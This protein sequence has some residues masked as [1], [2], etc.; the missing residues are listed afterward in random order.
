MPVYYN[1]NSI[2]PAPFISFEKTYQ[3][4]D[5]GTIV[6]T[7]W[8]ISVKGTLSAYKGSPNSTG[9]FWNVGG[10]PPDEVISADS[11]LTSI[12]RKQ[13]AL[14]KLFAVNG[15]TYEV[16]PWDGA[17]PLKF[18]PR[19]KKIIFPEGKWVEVCPYEIIMEADVIYVN[20]GILGEDSLVNQFFISKS[21]ESWHIEILN[22]FTREYRLVH[23]L[24]AVGKLFYDSNGNIPNPAWVNAQNYVLNGIGL[25]LNA[26]MMQADGVLGLDTWQAFNYIR[27]QTVNETAGS[28]EA[29]ETWLCFDTAFT[30]DGIG[31]GIPAVEVL[32]VTTRQSIEDARTSVTLEGNITGLEQRDNNTGALITTRSTNALSKYNAVS[33]FFQ[34]RAQA[35]SGFTMNPV[36]LVKQFATNNVNGTINYNVQFNNRAATFIGGALSE[37]VTV[38]DNIGSDVFAILPIPGRAIGPIIQPMGTVKENRRDI[39]IEIVM[40][41]QTFGVTTVIPN[42]DGLVALFIPNPTFG[43]LQ[44]EKDTPSWTYFTGRYSRQVSFVYQ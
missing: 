16:Q 44:K 29:T 32:T 17:P 25:G 24:G 11:R 36:P 26:S 20:G 35:F 3:T 1:S 14:R 37:I 41:A 40:P 38:I 15:Q 43:I 21:N 12:L 28:F 42:T 2:I 27:S 31:G 23:T 7:S 33:P 34:T 9:V 6:G 30:P 19:I 39:T 4:N 13:E 10:Y 18:N 5:D 22:E 8:N